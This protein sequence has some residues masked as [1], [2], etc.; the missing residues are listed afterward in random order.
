MDAET[1]LRKQRDENLPE[2]IARDGR[3]DMVDATLFK[4]RRVFGRGFDDVNV[5]A[6]VCEVTLDQRQDTTPDRTEADYDNRSVN[7]TMIG[8]YIAHL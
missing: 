5:S 8:I 1:T 4:E 7:Y 3:L 2:V 6:V